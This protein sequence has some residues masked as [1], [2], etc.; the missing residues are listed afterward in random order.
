MSIEFETILGEQSHP[1]PDP[2]LGT[3]VFLQAQRSM[4][5]R[6]IG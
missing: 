4:Q 6:Q 1:A 2:E 3:W 5:L